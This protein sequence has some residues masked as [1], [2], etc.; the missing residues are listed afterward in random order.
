[1]A[2]VD[3]YITSISATIGYTR[4]WMVIVHGDRIAQVPVPPGVQPSQL[5]RVYVAVAPI[6]RTLGAQVAY[7]A[8]RHA[9]DVRLASG[10][11]VTPTPFNAAVPGVRPTELFTPVPS[12]TPAPLVTGK[13][14]PRR[15]PLPA[16]ESTP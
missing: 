15:T 8:R 16:P 1:M 11:L 2:P 4:D 3:P 13:P 14:L 5:A 7:D 10:P 6:L 9:L 12:A